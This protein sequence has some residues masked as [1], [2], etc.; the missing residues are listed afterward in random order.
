MLFIQ[1]LEGPSAAVAKPV[2][3]TADPR[4]IRELADLVARRMTPGPVAVEPDD[5]AGAEQDGPRGDLP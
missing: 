1:L 4:I 3:V 2:L 5:D